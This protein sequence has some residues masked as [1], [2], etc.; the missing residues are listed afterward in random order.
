[1][2]DWT[3]GKG[4]AASARVPS[5]MGEMIGAMAGVMD[6]HTLA[7]DLTDPDARAEYVAYASLEARQRLAASLLRGIAEEMAGYEDLPMGRHDMDV[8]MSQDLTETFQNL[9]EAEKRLLHVLTETLAEHEAM[10]EGE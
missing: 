5:A 2:D 9:V 8:L 7:L 6:G 10:L 3:C 4:L 1:M